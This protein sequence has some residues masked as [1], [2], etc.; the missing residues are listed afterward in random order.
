MSMFI[1]VP[2]ASLSSNLVL[3]DR[4]R[5]PVIGRG[6]SRRPEEALH[7]AGREADEDAADEL[8]DRLADAAR[9]Y[10]LKR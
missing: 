2:G 7:A 10:A 5:R 3:V 9:A 4:G 6:P 1:G 8:L